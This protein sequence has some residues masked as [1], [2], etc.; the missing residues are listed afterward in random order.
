MKRKRLDRD[1]KWGFQYYPYYQFHIDSEIFSGLVSLIKLTDGDYIYWNL[2]KAGKTSVCGNGMTW[3]Q[4]IPDNKRRLITAMYLPMKKNV[5][6]KEF[7]Y[8]ISVW[9]VDIIEGIDYD[10]D[11]VAAYYDKFLDVIFTPQGDV[12]IDD[13]DELEEAYHLGQLSQEQY[14]SAVKE[15]ELII[16]EMCSDIEDTERWCAEVYEIVNEKIRLYEK[17]KKKYYQMLNENSKKNDV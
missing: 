15:C 8:S 17:P 16:K 6:G 10:I 3:L 9:Y 12:I 13:R 5:K 4:L 11:G 2:P 7:S 14:E 1:L